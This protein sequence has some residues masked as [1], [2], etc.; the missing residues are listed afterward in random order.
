VIAL[1]GSKQRNNNPLAAL[2]PLIALLANN[3]DEIPILPP[4]RQS[5]IDL[6][7]LQQPP[8]PQPVT[9]CSQPSLLQPLPQFVSLQQ[10]YS[11][12]V[13]GLI[14]EELESKISCPKIDTSICSVPSLINIINVAVNGD[15]APAG[16]GG[17][18]AFPANPTGL[19][20][21]ICNGRNEC[22]FGPTIAQSILTTACQL[23]LLA[24]YVALPG[25]TITA[26]HTTRID[27]QYQCVNSCQFQG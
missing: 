16:G 19:L 27:V 20:S 9:C 14:N 15:L 8:N 21:P 7:L 6:S 13:T 2:I 10:T 24:E 22:S 4:Q 1:E 5:N 18:C 17:T 11:F 25:I 23:A 3:N 12:G 26:V